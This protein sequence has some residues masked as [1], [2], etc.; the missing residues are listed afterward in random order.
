MR[1]QRGGQELI[2]PLIKTSALKNRV[3]TPELATIIQARSHALV[4]SDGKAK[5]VV[6]ILMNVCL[7]RALM[8][9]LV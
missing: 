9:V 5:R 4:L 2:V 3:I 8:V 7:S 1:V 6:Q